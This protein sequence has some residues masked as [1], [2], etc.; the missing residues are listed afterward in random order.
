MELIE[1]ISERKVVKTMHDIDEAVSFAKQL[2]QARV[3]NQDSIKSIWNNV[4]KFL[5][6]DPFLPLTIR[7][8][9]FETK[10]IIAKKEVWKNTVK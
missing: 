7:V 4:G 10:K 1:F 6:I 3:E 5:K 8:R 2:R 9:D